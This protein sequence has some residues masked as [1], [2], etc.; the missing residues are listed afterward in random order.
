MNP[1]AVLAA[2]PG[3]LVGLLWLPLPLPLP[4]EE[5]PLPELLEEPTPLELVKE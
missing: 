5:P 2:P 3:K 1:A 4:V